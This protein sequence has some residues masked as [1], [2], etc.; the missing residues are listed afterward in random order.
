MLWFAR[1]SGIG[2]KC[3]NTQPHPFLPKFLLVLKDSECAECGVT[4]LVIKR[5]KGYESRASV[6]GFCGA[7][8]GCSRKAMVL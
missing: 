7:I 3:G 2:K 8:G 4:Q 6:T 5:L 1:Y